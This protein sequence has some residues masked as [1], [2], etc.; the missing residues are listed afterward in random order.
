MDYRVKQV[1]EGKPLRVVLKH[2]GRG[3]KLWMWDKEKHA[4][5]KKSYQDFW[6]E[7]K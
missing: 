6:G 4:K 7:Q 3:C 5:A 1:L 2:K